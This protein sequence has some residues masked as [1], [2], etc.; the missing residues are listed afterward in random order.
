MTVVETEQRVMMIGCS[1]SRTKAAEG[2]RLA[3][4]NMISILLN[5]KD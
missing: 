5:L 1:P 2:D 4:D 3:H